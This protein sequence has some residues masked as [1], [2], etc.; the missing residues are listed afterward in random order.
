MEISNFRNEA[1]KVAH[2][3]NQ[4]LVEN[5]RGDTYSTFCDEF[6]YQHERRRQVYSAVVALR[7]FATRESLAGSGETLES[8]VRPLMAWLSRNHHPHMRVIV[9]ATSAEMLEGVESYNTDDFIGDK[10]NG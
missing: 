10:S 4:W 3:Y 1:L 8:S 9:D 2:Q 5:G 6:G 7:S